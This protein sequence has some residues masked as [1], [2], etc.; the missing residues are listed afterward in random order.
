MLGS[1]HFTHPSDD[2]K[3][4]AENTKPG[5]AYFAYTGPLDKCCGDCALR[6]YTRQSAKE[7]YDAT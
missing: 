1:S 7:Y 6:G 3:M 5:M 4:Q 2:A